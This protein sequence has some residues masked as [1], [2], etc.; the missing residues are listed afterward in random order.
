MKILVFGSCNIDYVY[1]VPHFVKP[2]ETI[3]ATRRE[4]FP[5]GKGLNQCIAVARSGVEVYH[6]G[7]IGKDGL[8]LKAIL[9]ES[10]ANTQYLK[11]IDEPSGHAIIQVDDAGENSIILCPGANHAIERTD[12]DEVLSHFAP[13]DMILLQNEIS[14]IEAIIE[15][16]YERGMQIVLNPS[17]FHDNLKQLDLNKLSYLILNEV[18]AGEFCGSTEPERIFAYFREEFSELRVVLTLGSKG[19]VYFHK[20]SEVFCPSFSVPVEDTTSAGDTFTGYFI[21]GIKSGFPIEKAL[22]TASAAAALAVSKKGA[23]SSIPTMREVLCA[24]DVLQPNRGEDLE[25]DRQ[26]VLVQ[27]YLEAHLID[28]SLGGVAEVLGYSRSYASVWMKEYMKPF[29]VLLKET[30]CDTAA[31]LLRRTNTPIGEIVRV[32]GYENGS[33]FRRLFRERFGKSPLEYRRFYEHNG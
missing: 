5:G 32:C 30:R 17:P 27:R 24:L 16:A 29:S 19:S 28:A 14:N 2:G 33:F 12:I 21:S 26:R 13:G 31:R 8:F 22:K 25:I 3:G 4:C 9:E 20:G 15:T 1:S 6:A 10:G 18:E 23:S 7:C 11:V